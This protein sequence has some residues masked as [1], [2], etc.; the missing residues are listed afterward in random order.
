MPYD[1]DPIW[2]AAV[3]MPPDSPLHEESSADVCVV[4]GGIAGLTT[5]YLA[6]G[7]G[8]SVLVLDAQRSVAS[9]ETR[10]TTAHLSC[11]IDDRLAHVEAIHGTDALVLAVSSHRSAIDFIE[12]TAAAEGIDCGFRRVDG[13][14]FLYKGED[15]DVLH[16]EGAAARRAGLAY[17]WQCALP[18]PSPE[19]GPALRFPSQ[20]RF[21][22]ID[23]M[24]GLRA[25][26]LRRGVR[27]GTGVPV[28]SIEGGPR[29][30]IRLEG[31][32][33]V[34]AG[35]CVVATNSPI[36]DVVALHTK[37][38]PYMTYAVAVPVAAVP[39]ALY[40]DTHDPYYYARL[41]EVDGTP[42]LIAG[43]ADHKTGQEPD[44]GHH[45][46][47]VEAWAARLFPVTGPPRWRWSGQVMETLDGLAYIG[48]DPGGMRNV[49]IATGDSGMGMTHGTIAGLLL[50]DLLAGRGHAW[51]RLYDPSRKPLRAAGDFVSE[52]ANVAA[53]YLSWLTPG[54]KAE[55]DLKPG[56]GAVVR[57]GLTKLAVYRDEAGEIHRHSAACPHLGCVVAWNSAGQTFDCPCHGSRFS[58]EGKV[59]HGPASSDLAP[60]GG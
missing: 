53:Q 31:G 52:N 21:H 25:A 54:E 8:A 2:S 5:A 45:W 29:A 12:A 41:Q 15:E 56:E 30:R 58:K 55:A 43:G 36:N 11:V 24:R 1:T 10:F 39:D 42:Y 4:G 17:E 9:G 37:Q 3:Q 22:P 16:K 51:A 33:S 44:P 38:A 47:L 48:P 40:W 28:R 50:R 49:F 57:G 14:L 20:G 6:A 18:L 23:Y 60:A 35:R 32:L 26:C 46:S 7:D 27:F 59:L 34:L 19:T 13:H